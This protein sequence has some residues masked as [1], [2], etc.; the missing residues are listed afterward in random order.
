MSSKMLVEFLHQV[1]LK[2]EVLEPEPQLLG[3][4][5]QQEARFQHRVGHVGDHMVLAQGREEAAAQ[6]RLAGADFARDLDEAFARVEADQQRVERFL[7]G[8]GRIDE[9]GVRRDAEG[10]FAQAEVVEVHG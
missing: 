8:V 4:R 10:K 1:K 5:D 9:A 2:V 7:V 3:D 6:Q